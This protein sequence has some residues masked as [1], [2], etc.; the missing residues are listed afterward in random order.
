MKQFVWPVRVYYEDTDAG[1]VV[2]YASYLRFMERARSEWLRSIGL[3]QEALSRRHG[4]LF[5]VRSVSLDYRRAARLDDLLEVRSRIAGARGARLV[6]D[7][8][9]VLP[10]AAGPPLCQGQVTVACVQADS[11]RPRP[12]PRL[13]LTE[14]LGDG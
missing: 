5:V 2:Y 6:F 8:A 3:H 4:V 12:L 1:G 14:M 7:Q 13:L 11:F 10:D 9:V